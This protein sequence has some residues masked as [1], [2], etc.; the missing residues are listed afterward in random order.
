MSELAT[1]AE[2]DV[3][4]L[5]LD[6][7]ARKN[8]LQIAALEQQG[9]TF[10]VVTND[11][12]G[13]SARIFGE[14]RFLRSR[15][16]VSAGSLWGKVRLAVHTIRR[17]GR[18][19]VELYAAGRMTFVALLLFKLLRRKYV[20][21]ERGD[22]GC[23]ADYDAASKLALKLAYRFADAVVYKETYM[24]ELLRPLTAAPLFFVPNCV[25]P[26]PEAVPGHGA[27]TVDFLWV[28][29]I[30]PQRRANWLARALNDPR[31]GRSK[32]RILGLEERAS[33][34]A[35]LKAQ[36]D[37]LRNLSGERVELLGFLDPAPHYLDARFFCLPS[38]IVF[39]N[40]S[41]IE[42]MAR[43][44]VPIVTEAP[45]VE[46]IVQDGVNGIVSAF[47]EDAYREALLRAAAL[48]AEAWTRLSKA[49]RATVEAEYSPR[50]WVSR[51][52]GVY[53][54]LGGAKRSRVD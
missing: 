32:A 30:T 29:R 10:T 49:A 25:D 11:Q 2:R 41:L 5:N 19:H 34:P 33:L 15:I 16:L 51:M 54:F 52:A 6:T 46:L 18:H 31:F 44:V 37:E 35:F 23:L 20:V 9:W 50:I 24:L 21:V 26:P 1:P 48:D 45:G 43:G 13:D 8:V 12:R 53:D 4:I 3:L 42:A 27:R 14:Q 17:F 38:S 36:Q 7:F 40:N 39:G 22:I 47:D 28:N